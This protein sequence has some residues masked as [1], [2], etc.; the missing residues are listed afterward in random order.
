VDAYVGNHGVTLLSERNEFMWMNFAT[1]SL[2]H[3][4]SIGKDPFR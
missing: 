1:K 2:Q 3:Y 4:P